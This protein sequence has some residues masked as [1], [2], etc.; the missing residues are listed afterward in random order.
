MNDGARIIYFPTIKIQHISNSIELNQSLEQFEKY[1]W[2]VFTSSNAVESFFAISKQRNLE[3]RWIKVAA[4]GSETAQCCKEH[5]LE[6]SLVPAEFSAVG[7]LK[8]F[9]K[10]NLLGKKIFIPCSSLSRKVLSVG[11]AEL[12]AE[13]TTVPTYA[14]LE[15]DLN[16][17][18][19]E[20]TQIQNKLPDIFVF[21]S[22]SSFVNYLSLLKVEDAESYFNNAI[23]CSIGKTTEDAIKTYGINVNI[24]PELFSLRGVEEAIKKYYSVTQNIA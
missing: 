10:M 21:T 11:L 23:I 7:L 2:I 16:S 3:L 14:V 15:N 6:V 4:V 12:G 1:D 20:L 17:L 5:N 24:V 22:P 8:E 19:E 18:N 9:S 13:V